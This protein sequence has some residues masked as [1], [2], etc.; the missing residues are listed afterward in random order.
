MLTNHFWGGS[1]LRFIATMM[2]LQRRPVSFLWRVSIK[3]Q[4]PKQVLLGGGSACTIRAFE[5]FNQG[6][7]KIW[8][9]MLYAPK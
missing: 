7:R 9:E 5:W 3:I 6:S 4:M 8:S 1:L 2:V